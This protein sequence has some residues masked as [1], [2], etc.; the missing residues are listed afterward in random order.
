MKKRCEI[1][2]VKVRLGTGRYVNAYCLL[3]HYATLPFIV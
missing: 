1:V 2:S 3:C